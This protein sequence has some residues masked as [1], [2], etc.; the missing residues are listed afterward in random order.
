MNRRL[1]RLGAA[2]DLRAHAHRPASA[3]RLPQWYP[4]RTFGT[5]VTNEARQR[6]IYRAA[7]GAYEWALRQ[8]KIDNRR[9][10]IEGH[11]QA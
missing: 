7:L 1:D 3:A 2:P 11:P 9:I 8:D 10:P 6:M 4:H 5:S